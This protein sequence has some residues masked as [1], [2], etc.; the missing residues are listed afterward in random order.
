[1]QYRVLKKFRYSADGI[2]A[3]IATP[4]GYPREFG[5]PADA[6]KGLIGEGYIEPAAPAPEDPTHAEAVAAYVE[7]FGKQPHGNMRTETILKKIEAANDSD[8]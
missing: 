5:L 1:M 2:T 7:A 8:G 6:L 3:Q 4:S